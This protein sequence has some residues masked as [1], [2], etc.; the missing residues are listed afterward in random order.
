MRARVVRV[1]DQ[2]GDGSVVVGGHQQTGCTGDLG[3]S[4]A[5]LHG[6]ILGTHH[7]SRVYVRYLR[8]AV[9]PNA[10]V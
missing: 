6:Q 3:K 7:G 10:A 2:R 5:Q 4:P 1:V 8:G 9:W